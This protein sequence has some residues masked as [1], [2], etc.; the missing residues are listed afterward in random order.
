[1]PWCTAISTKRAAMHCHR[2]GKCCACRPPSVPGCLLGMQLRRRAFPRL[3]S[4]LQRKGTQSQRRSRRRF[5]S[6]PDGAQHRRI[7]EHHLIRGQ[8]HVKLVG[9]AAAA[10]RLE[11]KGPQH[12][13]WE[14]GRDR[15]RGVLLDEILRVSC[16]ASH[17]SAPARGLRLCIGR[18]AQAWNCRAKQ[19]ML[20]RLQCSCTRA[21][22]EGRLLSKKISPT[23]RLCPSPTY[24]MALRDGTHL[25]ASAASQPTS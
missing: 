13:R 5:S 19:K 15:G 17:A 8:Q 16:W 18:P 10:G 22:E 1:M 12:L 6:S 24:T 3:L 4:I 14:G 2:K 11:L 7:L 21:E 20:Q 25:R 9:A 23:S